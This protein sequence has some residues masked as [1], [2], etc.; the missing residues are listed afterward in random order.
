MTKLQYS[1]NIIC[2]LFEKF[3]RWIG[4]CT[5]TDEL[6]CLVKIFIVTFALDML[7]IKATYLLTYLLIYIFCCIS[8]FY[9]DFDLVN[10]DD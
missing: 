6:C 3:Q 8:S 1:V 9:V 5:W 2:K 7:L 4:Y 10:K